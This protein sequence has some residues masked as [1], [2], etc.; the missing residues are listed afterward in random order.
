MWDSGESGKPAD[1]IDLSSRAGEKSC[2]GRQGGSPEGEFL[3]PLLFA[4]FRPSVIRGGPL[5]CIRER[6]PL[7]WVHI[8]SA[9]LIQK[10]SHLHTG[11]TV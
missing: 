8:L 3:L 2:L 5:A 7:Q 1:G 4:L 10:H 11:N 9:N 6:S